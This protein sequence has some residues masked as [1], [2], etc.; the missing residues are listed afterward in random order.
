M[1]SYRFVDELAEA[2]MKNL[3]LERQFIKK[4]MGKIT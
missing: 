4:W 1:F 2:M 3:F